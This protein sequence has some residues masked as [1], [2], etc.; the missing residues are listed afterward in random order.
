[1]SC[2]NDAKNH[3]KILLQLPIIVSDIYMHEDPEDCGHDRSVEI[4]KQ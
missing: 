3:G 2:S 4:S 1:M